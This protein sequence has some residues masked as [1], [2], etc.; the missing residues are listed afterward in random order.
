M[1]LLNVKTPSHRRLPDLPSS[2]GGGIHTGTCPSSFE[3]TQVKEIKIWLWAAHGV[4]EPKQTGLLTVGRNIMFTLPFEASHSRFDCRSWRFTVLSQ[5]S[6]EAISW[7]KC[8][9]KAA[10]RAWGWLEMIASVTWARNWRNVRRWKPSPSNATQNT[11]L[12]VI[13]ICEV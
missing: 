3:E 8:Q 9:L 12:F 11:S 2:R 5:S 7:R 4:S 1:K 13:V 6:P 10:V